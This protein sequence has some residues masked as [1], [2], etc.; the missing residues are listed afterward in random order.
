MYS[1]SVCMLLPI[2]DEDH[3][4]RISFIIILIILCSISFPSPSLSLLSVFTAHTM[5]GLLLQPVF[6]TLLLVYFQSASAQCIPG[7]FEFTNQVVTPD[8]VTGYP[9]ACVNGSYTPI[10]NQ[11][12][13]GP[14]ELGYMCFFANSNTTGQF[15][16]PLSPSFSF[17]PPSLSFSPPSPSL[18][19]FK[20]L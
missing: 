12:T 7:F 18:P 16:L 8:Y 1:E 4:W 11:T 10:C 20:C 19:L 3:S 13:L 15:F 9:L 6:L 14:F 17:S 2:E 5:K